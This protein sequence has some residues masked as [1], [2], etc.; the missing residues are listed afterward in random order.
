MLGNFA[1]F[2]VVS[3]FFNYFFQNI[4]SEIQSECQTTVTLISPDN[5]SGVILVQT[6]CKDNQ[7]MTLAD[8]E[9]NSLIETFRS[10][11]V[12]LVQMQRYNIAEYEQE[13]LHDSIARL[14]CALQITKIRAVT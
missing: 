13:L 10:F 11:L 6:V 4:L 5:S 2:F 7:Q 14:N 8:K 9:L 12:S 1:C 3:F